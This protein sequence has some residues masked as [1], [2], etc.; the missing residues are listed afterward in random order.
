MKD[1]LFAQMCAQV[2]NDSRVTA[3][4]TCRLG[5]ICSTIEIP[6]GCRLS[7]HHQYCEMQQ[8]SVANTVHSL[9]DLCGTQA[10]SDLAM[11][12]TAYTWLAGGE[13]TSQERAGAYWWSNSICSTSGQ[14]WS[15][16]L[17]QG[18]S[19]LSCCPGPYPPSWWASS[20]GQ[21]SSAACHQCCCPSDLPP[22]APWPS[23][24]GVLGPA[25][26]PAAKQTTNLVIIM[27][28][29]HGS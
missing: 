2:H 17:L 15:G 13:L 7:F 20:L 6:N 26:L 4:Y 22:W 18:A 3:S 9:Y 23:M 10:Y 28:N 16:W 25:A 11:L 24:A 1:Q 5:S 29:Y 27:S 14:M 12:L 21:S 19:G 8:A